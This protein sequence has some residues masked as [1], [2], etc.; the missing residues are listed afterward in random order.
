MRE[1]FQPPRKTIY[2]IFNPLKQIS[3]YFLP[4]SPLNHSATAGSKI[5]N[6][7]SL[8]IGED[9]IISTTASFLI[10]YLLHHETPLSCLISI[11]ISDKISGTV[12]S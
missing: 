1:F 8:E 7:W 6:P 2:N 11:P 9:L 4:P 12:T 3:K 5:T 10:P